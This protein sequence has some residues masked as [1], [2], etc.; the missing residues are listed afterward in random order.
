V[1]Y[2]RSKSPS[3]GSV[4]WGLVNPLLV[5]CI[6]VDNNINSTKHLTASEGRRAD[7]NCR[8]LEKANASRKEHLFPFWVLLLLHITIRFFLFSA[9]TSGNDSFLCWCA[10]ISLS[11]QGKYTSYN[12]NYINWNHKWGIWIAETQWC[13]WLQADRCKPF[14][15]LPSPVNEQKTDLEDEF[16]ANTK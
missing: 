16:K 11:N 12:K 3:Q 14:S 10:V 13:R 6:S 5:C 2:P 9:R 4:E 8:V 7:I 15:R 1:L